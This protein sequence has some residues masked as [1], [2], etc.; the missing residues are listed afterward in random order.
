MA[1]CAAVTTLSANSKSLI[2]LQKKEFSLA[3]IEKSPIH[4]WEAHR[5]EISTIR[6][7]PT[8]RT[9][10]TAAIDNTIKLWTDQIPQHAIC[11]LA[12]H[13]HPVRDFI[14]S[15]DDF[16]FSCASDG[17]V[18]FWDMEITKPLRSLEVH[19]NHVINSLTLVSKTLVLTASD[20]NTV[21]CSDVRVKSRDIRVFKNNFPCTSVAASLDGSHIYVG[22]TTGRV[23]MHDFGSGEHM[24]SIEAHKNVIT[25]LAREP[26][27]HEQMLSFALDG[28]GRVWDIRPF[29]ELDHELLWKFE[30]DL[31]PPEQ[32]LFRP[33]WSKQE[34]NRLVV[35]QATPPYN[36]VFWYYN[37]DEE[38]TMSMCLASQHK[39]IITSLD[40]HPQRFVVASAD[41]NG[42]VVCSDMSSFDLT[43]LSLFHEV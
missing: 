22:D 13:R 19:K 40:V 27:S 17:F 29:V 24:K 26:C 4:Q 10:A 16:C 23:H 9:L 32:I 28:S 6:Y 43:N 25:S 15:S 37:E 42:M 35:P 36:L 39:S 21:R 1:S 5:G 31:F 14:W 41:T 12:G 2:N 33:S 11:T 8:G 20:D 34:K 30:G 3:L 7:S 38:K 18:V